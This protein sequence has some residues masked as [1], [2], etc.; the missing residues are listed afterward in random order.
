M[1]CE[2]KI[3]NVCIE[4]T[5]AKCVEYVGEL[6]ETTKRGEIC[7]T[8]H[9]VNEDLYEIVDEIITDIGTELPSETEATC[10]S[11]PVVAGKVTPKAVMK[12][13][14]EEICSLKGRVHTLEVTNY[15]EMDI[16]DFGLDFKC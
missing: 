12:K 8:Q 13:H 4:T 14:R 3:Q 2:N 15:A 11:Y 5:N 7:T 16:T 9:M 1:K 6:G 10:I